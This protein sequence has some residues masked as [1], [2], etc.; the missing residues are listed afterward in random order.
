[1]TGSDPVQ[2]ER[3]LKDAFKNRALLY[4]SIYDELRKE[5]WGWGRVSRRENRPR[6]VYCGPVMRHPAAPLQ[7]ANFSSAI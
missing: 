1:M 6:L 2:L 3:E 4:W 5:G 7:A